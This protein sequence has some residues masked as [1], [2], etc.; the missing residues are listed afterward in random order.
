M[1][2]IGGWEFLLI[3]ILGIIIIGPKELPGAI[4]TLSKFV[5]HARTL[6]REFQSG[7]EE[8]AHDAEINK[9]TDDLK[10]IAGAGTGDFP[11]GIQTVADP[12]ENLMDALD[13][14]S[15]WTDDQMIDYHT[16]EF[17]DNNRIAV[18]DQTRNTEDVEEMDD[19]HSGLNETVDSDPASTPDT[20]RPEKGL[21]PDG[22][23]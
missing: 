21:K 4:R 17:A 23:S 18:T 8:V 1:L 10:E 12:D 16:P 22:G 20:H 15:G 6:T 7:L 9:L 19:P 14:P 2:D 11:E 5:A 3:A 13:L